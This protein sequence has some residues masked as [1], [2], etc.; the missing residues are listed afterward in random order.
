MLPFELYRPASNRTNREEGKR[1][2]TPRR[3]KWLKLTKW[4]LIGSHEPGKSWT[5]L[6][7]RRIVD[8]SIVLL[9]TV[10]RLKMPYKPTEVGGKADSQHL[11]WI[12]F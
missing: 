2:R 10:E 3:S 1:S 9:Y 6:L 5:L 7:L 8:Q 12:V 11:R 4:W